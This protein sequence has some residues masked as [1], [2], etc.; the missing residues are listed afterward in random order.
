MLQLRNQLREAHR[1]ISRL[2]KELRQA[3]GPHLA[4]DRTKL[5]TLRRQVAF[6][7]HPDRGGDERLMQHMNALFDSLECS[8]WTEEVPT[9]AA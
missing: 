3:T 6:H 8:E 5:R 7:C 9:N 1:E 2:K 4:I